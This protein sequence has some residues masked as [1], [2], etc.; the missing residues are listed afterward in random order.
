MVEGSQN[1]DSGN[2]SLLLKAVSAYQIDK[3]LNPDGFVP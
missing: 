3:C 1:V 2:L